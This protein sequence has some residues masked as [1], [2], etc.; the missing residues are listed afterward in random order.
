[1]WTGRWLS[2][3][4]HLLHT[5]KDVSLDLSTHKNLGIALLAYN[6]SAEGSRDRIPGACQMP[7]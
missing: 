2:R 4:Q 7:A 3:E 5:Y 6:L 1:M